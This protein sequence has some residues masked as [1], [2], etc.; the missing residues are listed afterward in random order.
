MFREHAASKQEPQVS[1]PALQSGQYMAP[2][3]VVPASQ[4]GQY[5]VSQQAAP[6]RGTLILQSVLVKLDGRTGLNRALEQMVLQYRTQV[7]GVDR[8]CQVTVRKIPRI[9][10]WRSCSRGEL[11]PHEW[12]G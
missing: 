8:P 12:S 7:W 2:Y 6:H 11:G 4:P 9:P 1:A 3:Q 5:L 10:G